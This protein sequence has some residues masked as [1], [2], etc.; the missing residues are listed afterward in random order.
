M[1]TRRAAKVTVNGSP[2]ANGSV[3]EDESRR[4]SLDDQRPVTSY[5]NGSQLSA[6]SRRLSEVSLPI[7][8]PGNALNGIYSSE[9]NGSA[10]S[11]SQAFSRARQTPSP[12]RKRKRSSSSNPEQPP[13]FQAPES[14]VDTSF[15][16]NDA[17]PSY[18][19][20]DD[21][22]QVVSPEDLSDR[23]VPA[24][25]ASSQSEDMDTSRDLMT[26]PSLD[27]TPAVSGQISPVTSESASQE[28]LPLAKP[29]NAALEA[30]AQE[31]EREAADIPDD[32]DDAD[33]VD[34]QPRS[35][36]DGRLRRGRFGGRRRAKHPDS[37]VE[38]AMQRQ[39]T[40]KSTYRSIARVQKGLLA[41]I[42]LRT[43]DDLETNPELHTEAAEYEG[44]TEGLD[45]HLEERKQRLQAQHELSLRQLK[46]T[47]E[48]EQ[49]VIKSKCKQQFEDMQEDQLDRLEYEI[50]KIARAAQLDGIDAEYGTE[51]EDD[52]IPKP[53]G[54]GY[55]WKRTIALD[56]AYDS[57][58][59][60][61]LETVRATADME[62]RFNMR[63]LLENFNDED[64]P[65][66]LGGFTV[67]DSARREM[68][69]EKSEG[70]KTMSTLADAAARFERVSNIPIIPNEKALGLQML[71]D[72]ATRPSI[73]NAAP[74]SIRTKHSRGSLINHTP[75]GPRP[76]HLQLNTD[77]GSSPIPL[78]MSPRT[79]LA[80]GD[81]FDTSMPPPM[82]PRQNATAFIRSPETLR[83]DQPAP[84][85][86]M[87]A[88]RRNS[89]QQQPPSGSESRPQ[90]Q[91]GPLS[92][93][94]DSLS[95]TQTQQQPE[96][97]FD[98]NRAS[99]Q[100]E[101]RR[102]DHPLWRAY[103]LGQPPD[104]HRRA[105]SASDRPPFSFLGGPP[106]RNERQ[107]NADPRLREIQETQSKVKDER[108]PRS[109]LYGRPLQWKD[110]LSQPGAADAKQNIQR[111][112]IGEPPRP[113]MG[114]PRSPRSR[115]PSLSLSV[116]DFRPGYQQEDNQQHQKH[117]GGTKGNY[118]P[119]S[120][121]GDRGGVSRRKWKAGDHGTHSRSVG[122]SGSAESPTAAPSSYAG[123][124]VERA[125]PP[126]PWQGP[127]LTQHS[128]LGPPAPPAA[129][130]QQHSPYGPPPSP[131]YP[132]SQQGYD[133]YQHRNS[134][135]PLP[136]P[137][138]WNQP[139]LSPL[140]AIPQSQPQHPPP[141]GVPP[142]QYA[143]FPPPPP[144]GP[145]S[146][147]PPPPLHTTQ[148]PLS[149]SGSYGHQFGGPPLA[150]A[151][152]NPG[153]HP[154]GFRPAHPPPAF[155]QQAQQQQQ[156]NYGPRRRTQ[157]DVTGF[158]KFQPW[159]PPGS[160]R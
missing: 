153:F 82:T 47:L 12:S 3:D 81:R 36:D 142:E 24:S 69:K 5:S 102:N 150:P 85:P 91:N 27:M 131:Y 60:L 84:S 99:F 139:P 86:A 120:S 140:Y 68:A 143:R 113:V 134:F 160:R 23:E 28:D 46:D 132:A 125:A 87:K 111:S 53:K 96:R 90:S 33:D 8:T 25:Q 115:N 50:L 26:A 13:T 59:R 152:T 55:R 130:H 41:E 37:R 17:S 136:P 77:Y 74:A 123:S 137:P 72:L 21:A 64:K 159:N 100:A 22:A 98:G 110:P 61:A 29:L 106:M 104:T 135:P 75:P 11:A 83:P 39:A 7:T 116:H 76:P 117:K 54:M 103:P 16:N 141:P 97:V 121:K 80:M 118:L 128:T 146:Y 109:H 62:I 133:Y 43:V 45:G 40:L 127:P 58:S 34:E 19:D 124:P 89:L 79:T 158:P 154:P 88:H 122:K 108:S 95:A 51:D 144:P 73:T 151:T 119:K 147:Q 155:A 52:V 42:A 15:E 63:K 105:S 48:S 157:S 57:R 30:A 145:P 148:P 2:S 14:F 112:P 1:K 18:E 35:D 114:A 70:V 66:E 38:A 92:E 78:V 9:E 149:A 56:S 6:K 156:S 71:G 126:A 101:E 94:K 67:M 44:V 65:K 49:R 32:M 20:E 4:G 31:A 129:H 138:G 10:R 107:I 93:H